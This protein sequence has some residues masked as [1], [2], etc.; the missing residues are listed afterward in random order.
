M[1]RIVLPLLVMFIFTL[2]LLLDKHV[3]I[4]EYVITLV[5][6]P[7]ITWVVVN[8]QIKSIKSIKKQLKDD[9]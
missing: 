6:F 7:T 5:I 2:P 4:F 8:K 9:E 3:G 1:K